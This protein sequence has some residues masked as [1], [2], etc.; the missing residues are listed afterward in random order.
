MKEQEKTKIRLE[1][2]EAMEIELLCI[3]K[4]RFNKKFSEES[5]EEFEYPQL[6]KENEKNILFSI[7]IGEDRDSEIKTKEIFNYAYKDYENKK[8]KTLEDQKKTEKIKEEF[9]SMNK[10]WKNA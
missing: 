4:E 7:Q 6:L 3:F 5:L 1:E 9:D 2:S 8:K 10:G